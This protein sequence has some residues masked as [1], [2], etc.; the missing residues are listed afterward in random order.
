MDL[1]SNIDEAIDKIWEPVLKPP[2]TQVSNDL[3]GF[4]YVYTENERIYKRVDKTIR[5]FD[6]LQI[7]FTCYLR[8][9]T[10]CINSLPSKHRNCKFGFLFSPFP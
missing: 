10:K 1:I 5:T 9:V 6:N 8:L 3:L 2:R 4:G 7:K